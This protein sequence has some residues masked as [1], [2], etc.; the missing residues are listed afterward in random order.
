ME[1]RPLGLDGA[2]EIALAPRGDERGYFVRTYD[3][4]LFAERSLHAAWVQENQSRSARAGTVR[5]MHF[6]RPPHAETKL[7]RVVRGA[8]FDVIVDLRRASPTYGEWTSIELTAENL[9]MLY[10]PKGFAHGF[11]TLADDT[12]V[13][14]KVDAAYAP[15]A[16]GGLPWDDPALAIAW[17]AAATTLSDR[18][19][20]HPPFASFESPF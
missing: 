16:E 17:P 12:V 20:R 6:Q 15:D 13:T 11:C 3:A 5:G 14:Y 4:A 1:F 19:R 2:W 8:V 9:R 18:D 10:V 7:V